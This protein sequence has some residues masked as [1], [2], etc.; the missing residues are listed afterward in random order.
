MKN[1]KKLFILMS[2]VFVFSVGTFAQMVLPRDS[3]R[4]TISQVIGDTS[5]SVVYHRPNTKGRKVWGELVPFGQVWRTGANEATVFEV[6]NDV[7]INGQLLPKGKYSLHTIPTESEWTLIFNKTWNQWGSFEYDAKQD[8]LR[9]SAKPTTGEMRET[10]SFD[11]GDMKPNSTQVVIAWDKVR[12]PFT[13]DVGDVNKRIVN[14]FRSKIIADPVQATNY[15][16]TAKIT[17][18][19][20][21]ALGWLNNSIAMRET[22]GNL[23]AKARL[24]NEMGRLNDAV[25]TAEKAIQVGKAATPVAN[26]NNLE[27]L[28]KGWKTKK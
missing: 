5:V 9:V 28:L 6:S 19:Y 15:I 13:I 3:Q 2:L 10:M 25:A 1:M 20:E 4:A 26:T 24:L 7:T 14:D 8:A 18:S 21:E 12:V 23:S 27:N 17:T 22:F 11:F 16:L